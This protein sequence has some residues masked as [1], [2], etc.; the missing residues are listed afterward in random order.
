LSLLDN[1]DSDLTANYFNEN[2]FARLG[3]YIPV[4]GAPAQVRGMIDEGIQRIGFDSELSQSHTEFHFLKNE[5][6][7]PARND[8]WLVDSV[9]YTLVSPI[10]DDGDVATWLVK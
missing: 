7:S 10:S 4:S 6:A 3:T 9:T 1:I 2:E 5:I 8:T